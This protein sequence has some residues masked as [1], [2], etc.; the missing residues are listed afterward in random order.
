VDARPE[1]AFNISLSKDRFLE[2]NFER[3]HCRRTHGPSTRLYSH[4]VDGVSPI[5][6][7]EAGYQLE[8]VVRRLVRRKFRILCYWNAE[9]RLTPL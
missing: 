4:S 9:S 8:D 5:G 7:F 1:N 3:G 6:A 2:Y